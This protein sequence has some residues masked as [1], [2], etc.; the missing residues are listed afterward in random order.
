M[1]SV[2]RPNTLPSDEVKKELRR[3]TDKLF[4]KFSINVIVT[5]TGSEYM[6]VANWKHRGKIPW[7][8]ALML[9]CNKQVRMAGFKDAY[10]FRPDCRGHV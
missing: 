9:C 7:D 2:S 1:Q 6:T 10:S 8:A 4:E 3:I 5:M